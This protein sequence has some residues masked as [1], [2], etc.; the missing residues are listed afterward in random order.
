M[1]RFGNE[2]LNAEENCE[3]R[4][5]GSIIFDKYYQSGRNDVPAFS[6]I[7]SNSVTIRL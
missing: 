5:S 4:A 6:P 2:A 7:E 3:L 1:R